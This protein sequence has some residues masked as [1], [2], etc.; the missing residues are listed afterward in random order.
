VD[1]TDKIGAFEAYEPYS[2][3]IVKQPD[4]SY[5]VYVVGDETGKTFTYPVSKDF[6]EAMYGTDSDP[7]VNISYSAL[8]EGDV[9]GMKTVTI[10][11][12]S[13][14]TYNAAA[15]ENVKAT[16]ADRVLTAS[17]DSN[18]EMT[19][20]YQWYANTSD[21][22]QGGTAISGATNNTFTIPSGLQAGTYYYYCVVS[23]NSK[24]ADVLTTATGTVKFVVAADESSTP[25][26]STTSSTTTTSGTT[27]AP[28]TGSH[29]LTMEL[30][31]LILA[32]AGA[33]LVLKKKSAQ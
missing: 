3:Q 33:M 20:T 2:I 24:S 7:M 18:P 17:A 11:K 29:A 19:Y 31:L 6:I 22:N 4:G 23:A 25:V 5:V 28:N 8:N 10:E 16:I 14:E 21:S 12:I 32:S 30:S 9:A 1:T 26:S 15:P 13:N 27:P